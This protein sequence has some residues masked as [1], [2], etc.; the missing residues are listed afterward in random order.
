[1]YSQALNKKVDNLEFKLGELFSGPGGLAL[2]AISAKAKK[3]NK[4]YS[5]RHGWASDYDLDTGLTYTK[6]I[7]NGSSR[8]IFLS[9]VTKLNFSKMPKIDAF[10]YGFPCND[11]SIVGE[12]KGIK[13]K[14]KHT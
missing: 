2:G 14:N 13:G 1:M 12:K 10:A 11:F 5:I 3:G 7:C 6:N 4:T 9:D 8:S